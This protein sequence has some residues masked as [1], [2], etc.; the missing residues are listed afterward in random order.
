[1]LS[2]SLLHHP[3]FFFCLSLGVKGPDESPKGNVTRLEQAVLVAL[4][5]TFI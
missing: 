2:D 4:C 1:M 3:F 5:M